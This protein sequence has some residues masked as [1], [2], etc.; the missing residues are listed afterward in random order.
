MPIVTQGR[1]GATDRDKK[2]E[3][4]RRRQRNQLLV[5]QVSI[6]SLILSY[7]LRCLNVKAVV[8]CLL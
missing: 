4:R 8:K 3:E 6:E 7:D 2:L 5:V 1:R